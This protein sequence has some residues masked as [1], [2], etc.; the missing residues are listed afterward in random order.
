VRKNNKA[1]KG[2]TL[3]ELM[4]VVAII[5]ILSVIAVPQFASYLTDS[6]RSDATAGLLRMAE[7]QERYY[8]QNNAYTA[9]LA[10]L[11]PGVV[12]PGLSRERL[13][14]FTVTQAGGGVFALQAVPVAGGA[15]AADADCP[16][17]TLNSAG[18]QAPA[19]CW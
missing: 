19:T 1:M 13:Y 7:Q 18:L 15:Q 14:N 12:N 8:I 6:R 10:L 2:F 9:N 11:F 3:I 17:I 16:T 4:I 5:G